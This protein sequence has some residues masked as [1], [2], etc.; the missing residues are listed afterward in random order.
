MLELQSILIG[1]I[2]VLNG[3][4]YTTVLVAKD[5]T[6]PHHGTGIQEFTVTKV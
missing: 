6:I 5:R 4:P 1:V 2:F 3:V